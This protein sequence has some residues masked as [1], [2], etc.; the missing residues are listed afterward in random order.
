[1]HL[2][3]P[4]ARRDIHLTAENGPDPFP[5]RR[6]IKIHHAV[7]DAVIGDGDRLLPKL[8]GTANQPLDT[9]GA[10]EQAVF[11]VHMQMDKGHGKSSLCGFSPQGQ[12]R[13]TQH[14]QAGAV[15]YRKG[16]YMG[17][18]AVPKAVR[19]PA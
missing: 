6:L 7:H 18:Q 4:G 10:V 12:Y 5:A 15:Q 14:Q 16:R 3:E 17:K 2:I 13:Y 19:I 8:T 9:A 11:T 1:M